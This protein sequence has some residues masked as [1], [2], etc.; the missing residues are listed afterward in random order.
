[1][2]RAEKIFSAS[3]FEPGSSAPLYARV[4]KLVQEAVSAGDL[5]VGDSIPSERDVAV[6]L[7]VSRATARTA[8]T[9]R[10]AEGALLQR[11]GSATYAT[12]P[13]RR[14]EQPRSR[15]TRLS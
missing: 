3:R 11:R 8:F 4:K 10:V 1:M 14:A 6:M 12:G 2:G 15:L 13:A 5:K 7:D 9:E